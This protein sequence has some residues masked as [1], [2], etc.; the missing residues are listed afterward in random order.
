MPMFS[1]DGVMTPDGAEAVYK[2]LA[3][4]MEKVRGATINLS[5]TYTN[6]FING[7]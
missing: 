1:P 4:S 2:L 7:R 3:G 5:N 6:E